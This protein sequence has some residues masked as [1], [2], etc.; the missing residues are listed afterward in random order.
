MPKDNTEI[1]RLRAE[2]ADAQELAADATAYRVLLP[3]AGG[4]ELRL[5]RQSTMSGDGWSVAVPRRGGGVAWTREGWQES[6]SALSVDRLFCWPDARTAIEE[7]RRA[8][9]PAERPQEVP[10]RGDADFFEPERNYGTQDGYTAPEATW[11]FDCRH[12][13]MTPE[14]DEIAF[15]FIRT[16]YA[17]WIPTGLGRADWDNKPWR[18][19][20]PSRSS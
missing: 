14:G 6:I 15:G 19:S 4:T 11:R 16:G 20:V 12:V 13:T 8:L 7:T 10:Q 2:L 3:E 1:T 9:G 5:S 18:V 17:D